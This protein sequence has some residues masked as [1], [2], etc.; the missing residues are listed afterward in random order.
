MDK[1]KFK[2]FEWP[3]NPETFRCSFEREPIFMRDGMGLIT[4]QP[5]RSG[6]AVASM[7]WIENLR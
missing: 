2:A 6:H 3:E 7:R 1:L 4:A 5:L